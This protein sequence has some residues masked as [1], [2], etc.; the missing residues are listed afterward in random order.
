[1]AEG[2]GILYWMV[3]GAVEWFRRGLTRTGRVASA[4][5]AYRKESDLMGQWFDE[6]TEQ[7]P[8]FDCLQR[9]TYANYVGWCAMQGLR[10]MCKKQLT[11]KLKER[12]FL[13]WQQSAGLRA[14][15]YRGFRLK[16]GFLQL[17]TEIDLFQ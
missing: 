16:E 4:S 5:A 13:T 3:Q 7:A 1:M 9:E 10:A 14:R 6:E 17:P 11:D 15:V 8:A 12:G 2:S